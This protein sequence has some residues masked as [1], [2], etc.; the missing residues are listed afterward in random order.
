MVKTATILT[1]C[2]MFPYVLCALDN[3]AWKDSNNT[4]LVKLF[5]LK[6]PFQYCI[7][8]SQIVYCP[9]KKEA[10]LVDPVGE[11]PLDKIKNFIKENRLKLKY[12]WFPT[13]LSSRY[14]ESMFKKFKKI[15]KDVKVIKTV[16][17][18]I[19]RGQSDLKRTRIVKLGKYKTRVIWSISMGRPVLTFIV[20][21][22]I[23]IG[24]RCYHGDWRKLLRQLPKKVR[25]LGKDAIIYR[26]ISIPFTLDYM[27]KKGF[28]PRGKTPLY[29]DIEFRQKDGKVMIDI[30]PKDC[31]TNRA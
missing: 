25:K 27:K 15:A 30:I 8:N 11:V 21:N 22:D 24:D 2:V 20:G 13:W 14:D 10:A 26:S 1:I 12:L 6:K 5:W 9:E 18:R 23:F 29:S 4:P 7:R 3:I 31:K 17:D 16:S 28:P 19:I